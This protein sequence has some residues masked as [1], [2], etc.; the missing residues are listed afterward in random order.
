MDQLFDENTAS[1]ETEENLQP[2]EFMTPPPPKPKP[3]K[4]AEMEQFWKSYKFGQGKPTGVISNDDPRMKQ[5]FTDG[6]ELSIYPAEKARKWLN[7]AQDEPQN[8]PAFVRAVKKLNLANYYANI[9]NVD[10]LSVLDNFDAFNK[11]FWGDEAESDPVK[12]A[13]KMARML[14]AD[15]PETNNKYL[16]AIERGAT[17]VAG[18][19]AAT[20]ELAARAAAKVEAP[21]NKAVWSTISYVLRAGG[22]FNGA[23][24]WIDRET[25]N[26]YF[27]D[28]E[29]A[30]HDAV[31][32][33]RK[34]IADN[35]RNAEPADNFFET[36]VLG[37]IENTP[38]L[39][40]GIAVS[41]AG[42][43][44]AAYGY[45]SIPQG[46]STY[47]DNE[48]DG[49]NP[50]LNL[51]HS[52]VTGAAEIAYARIGK[53]KVIE[54]WFG[55]AT[56][57]KEVAAGFGR[58]LF[59]GVARVMKHFGLDYLSEGIEENL[60]GIT[61]RF[62]D[63]ACGANGRSLDKISWSEAIWD[64]IKYVFD[65][66]TIAQENTVGG[67]LGG[68]TTIAG[69]PRAI[70]SD[71]SSAQFEKKRI[72]LRGELTNRLEHLAAIDQPSKIEQQEM[73]LI[74]EAIDHPTAANLNT[75]ALHSS[76][77][78]NEDARRKRAAEDEMTVDD[79]AAIALEKAKQL[80]DQNRIDRAGLGINKPEHSLDAIRTIAATDTFKGLDIT[81]ILNAQDLP[82]DIIDAANTL[83]INL[84]SIESVYH[85]SDGKIYAVAA[86]LPPSRVKKA[87]LHESFGHLGIQ[88]FMG[89]NWNSFIDDVAKSFNKEISEWSKSRSGQSYGITADNANE[90]PRQR[91]AAE[92]WLAQFTENIDFAK[93]QG[94][95]PRILA[96]LRRA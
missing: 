85:P 24:D 69:A 61:Q 83:G 35:T 92:E 41:V 6:G 54:K 36:C 29:K 15:Q 89:E 3:E 50:A 82:P 23:A 79:F 25:G 13:N 81:G 42:G 76:M 72:T 39:A 33:R 31:T 56:A 94:V 38:Q 60:T 17:N 68:A 46:A 75:A 57:R 70:M 78:Q 84:W 66:M 55:P 53:M 71:V 43:P 73:R 27:A 45:F 21:I 49:M 88:R 28:V 74:E 14:G 59:R 80:R 34:M 19:L 77:L 91:L 58:G 40:A 7:L 32:T 4:S 44:G 10:Q 86:N 47:L 93:K 62:A 48:H 63:V 37:C 22:V 26:S 2:V 30:F 11:R 8:R 5:A 18:D 96:A 65:P 64:T 9:Y 20:G 90:A 12:Q 51:L 16:A 87:L 95:L 52:T 1:V 67:L